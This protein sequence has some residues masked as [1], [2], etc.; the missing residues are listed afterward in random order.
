MR[1]SMRLST[2]DPSSPGHLA[3][4]ISWLL[5]AFKTLLRVTWQAV[6]L[7][8]LIAFHNVAHFDICPHPAVQSFFGTPNFV[9]P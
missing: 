9:I 7:N 6:T 8:S 4:S 2:R 5:R 3:N 1:L